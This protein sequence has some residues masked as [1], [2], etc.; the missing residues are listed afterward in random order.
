LEKLSWS[1]NEQGANDFG[2]A[3]LPMR[4]GLTTI[5]ASHISA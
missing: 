5:F 3:L 1:L 2:V 4:L